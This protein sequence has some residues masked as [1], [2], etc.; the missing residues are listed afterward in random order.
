MIQADKILQF[1]PGDIAV[2]YK[3]NDCIFY[4]LS[5][6]VGMDATD[7]L[8]LPFVYEKNLN[9]MPTMASILGWGGRLTDPAYGIDNRMVV[10][11]DLD[12]ELHR[13]LR[14]EDQLISQPRVSQ[15]ID[16]GE[17]QS[18][19][20]QFQRVLYQHDMTPVATIRNSIMARNQGGFGGNDGALEAPHVMPTR[21][22]DITCDLP[23]SNNLALLFRLHGDSNPI[24][25]DPQLA[26]KVGF[27]KP[28][29][30]GAAT[31]GVAGHALIR[32]VLKTQLHHF[33]RMKARFAKP[34]FP[35]DTLRTEIWIDG[36]TV[37]FRCLALER[38]EVT[39]NNGCLL[40]HPE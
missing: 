23:T 37:S 31:F 29:L 17:G 18:A 26:G 14:T 27:N 35:G 40:L 15:V 24:H 28:I 20:I 22:P 19:I 10:A 33:S 25:V 12:V 3:H 21:A 32:S 8:Q 11:S 36:L 39:L 1:N 13:P 2:N 4:A 6:G 34:F 5:V 38:N 16:K 30:H 7:T 9:V